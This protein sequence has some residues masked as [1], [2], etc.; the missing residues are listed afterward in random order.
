MRKAVIIFLTLF[1]LIL[2]CSKDWSGPTGATTDPY[3]IS[4]S[5]PDS[6]TYVSTTGDIIAY[7]SKDMDPSTINSGTFYLSPSASGSVT[8]NAS[9]RAAIFSPSGLS[10]DTIYYAILTTG[11]RDTTGRRMLNGYSWYFLTGSGIWVE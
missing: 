11:I 7:F 6:A 9:Q 3:V 5:P 1:P 8:Y 4:V 2:S 10:S